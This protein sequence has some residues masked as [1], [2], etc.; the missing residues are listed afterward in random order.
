MYSLGTKPPDHILGKVGRVLAAIKNRLAENLG[1]HL[2][3]GLRR[4][5]GEG[6][7]HG[8]RR[9]A[10]TLEANLAHGVDLVRGHNVEVPVRVKGDAGM[11]ACFVY[12]RLGK[13]LRWACRALDL[14]AHDGGR[15]CCGEGGEGGSMSCREDRGCHCE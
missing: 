10:L 8:I 9:D 1:T 13:L 5:E 4:E 11:A 2:L 12:E 3:D 7:G 14:G 6:L 15:R